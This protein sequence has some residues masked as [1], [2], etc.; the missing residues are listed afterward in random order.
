MR[1]RLGFGQPFL[2]PRGHWDDAELG[3]LQLGPVLAA[4]AQIASCGRC[5]GPRAAVATATNR[6]GLHSPCTGVPTRVAEAE[7]DSVGEAA[8]HLEIHVIVELLRQT[9][10]GSGGAVVLHAEGDAVSALLPPPS[11]SGGRSGRTDDA[12]ALRPPEREFAV[13]A[14]A[15]GGKKGR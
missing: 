9:L 10:E 5:V 6:F 1:S 7:Q 15:G 12:V 2:D 13:V 4:D 8:R 14:A 11:P 3:Q